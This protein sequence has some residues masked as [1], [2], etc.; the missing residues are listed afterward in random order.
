MQNFAWAYIALHIISFIVILAADFSLIEDI[1]IPFGIL[2]IGVI[3]ASYYLSYNGIKHYAVA[4]FKA[5][6]AYDLSIENTN[7]ELTSTKD[8]NTSSKEKFKT[9][10]LSQD[11][12]ED[13]FKKV[14]LLFENEKIYLEP[15][16]KIDVLAKQLNVSTHKVSQTIN[17]KTNE[18]FYDFV[19][20]YRVVHF[21]DLLSNPE[22]RKYTILALSIESGFNSKASLNRIFREYVGQSP[23]QFQKGQF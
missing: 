19:N 14:I 22:N 10:T 21:K 20:R 5:I 3:G 18:P 4:D 9:S 2:F 12:M 8:K 6:E 23:K 11:E 13:I 15:Q 17:S 16:L 1:K 7:D